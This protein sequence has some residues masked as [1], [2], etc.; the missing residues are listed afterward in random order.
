[1]RH[2]QYDRLSQQQQGL[3]F[4]VATNSLITCPDTVVMTTTAAAAVGLHKR[5]TGKY[6]LK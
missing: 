4:N 1:M 5:S 6:D 2:T 3:L